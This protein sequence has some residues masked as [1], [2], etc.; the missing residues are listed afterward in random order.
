MAPAY[1]PFN[2]CLYRE[3]RYHLTEM[4]S[5]LFVGIIAIMAFVATTAGFGFTIAIAQ[6]A[7]NATMGNMTG[8]NMTMGAG[9]ITTG[10][11]TETGSISG[12]GG[13]GF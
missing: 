4:K 9:N 2:I 8:G 10:N 3:P 13:P 5:I 11:S 6:M 7:D 1:E 12:T